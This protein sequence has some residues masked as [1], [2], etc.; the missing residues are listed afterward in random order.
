MKSPLWSFGIG[1]LVLY[2][3]VVVISSLTNGFTCLFSC[4]QTESESVTDRLSNFWSD[5]WNG[6]ASDIALAKNPKEP[7][8]ADGGAK[9]V[10]DSMV[11]GMGGLI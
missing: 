5:F 7:E 1:A 2:L 11:D 9:G 10:S 6:S 3:L 4:D 8:R